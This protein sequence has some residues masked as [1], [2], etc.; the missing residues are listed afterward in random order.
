MFFKAL[1]QKMLSIWR[2]GMLKTDIWVSWGGGGTDYGHMHRGMVDAPIFSLYNFLINCRGST[3][4]DLPEPIFWTQGAYRITFS[5]VFRSGLGLSF[6]ASAVL[7]SFRSIRVVALCTIIY[8]ILFPHLVGSI[9]QT[10]EQSQ[11]FYSL[12]NNSVHFPF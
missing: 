10:L 3:F 1:Q 4:E 9:S 2:H 5:D 6:T 11:T 8:Q 7:W 12:F